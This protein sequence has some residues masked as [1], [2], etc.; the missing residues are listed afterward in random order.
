MF[1]KFLTRISKYFFKDLVERFKDNLTGFDKVLN[2]TDINQDSISYVSNILFLSLFFFI[3]MEFILIFVM[4]NLNILFNFLSF[5]ITIFI[6]FTFT[7]MVF[8]LLL[9][10][11]YYILNLKKLKIKEELSRNIIHLSTLKDEKLKIEDVI[12][13]FKNLEDNDVLTKEAKKI[14]NL[15]KESHNLKDIFKIIINQTYSEIE[16]VFFRKMIKVIDKEEDLNKVIFEF[17][18]SLEQ[19]R[20]EINEQKKTRVNLLFSISFFLFFCFL[21]ILILIFMT[22]DNPY[23]LKEFLFIFGIVFSI[24]EFVIILVLF[25]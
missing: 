1:S 15:K 4:I 19:S 14:I 24:I 17:L 16:K 23:V 9:K 3:V 6:S 2:Y 8:L 25:K 22:I 10:Y 20:K 7:V 18:S 12:N 11:P 5:F 21:I 13:L